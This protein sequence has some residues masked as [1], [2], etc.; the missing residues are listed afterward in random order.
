MNAPV[1]VEAVREAGVDLR[2]EGDQVLCRPVSRLPDELRAALR[3]HRAELVA[4][5]RQQGAAG[6]MTA[7]DDHAPGRCRSCGSGLQPTE[8]DVCGTCRW[9]LERLAPERVQ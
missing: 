3:R 4:Y 8:T 5:L 1:L 2:V 9:T 6:A 7:T